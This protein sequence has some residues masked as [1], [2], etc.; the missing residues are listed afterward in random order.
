MV[1]NVM[2]QTLLIE[3]IQQ[4]LNSNAWL[5][6]MDSNFGMFHSIYEKSTKKPPNVTDW[7]IMLHKHASFAAPNAL[8]L[9]FKLILRQKW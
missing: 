1:L 3:L 8:M 5:V 7:V 2:P 9:A 4:F 6:G